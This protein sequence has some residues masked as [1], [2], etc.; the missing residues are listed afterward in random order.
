MSLAARYAEGADGC[1]EDGYGEI[2]D[3]LDDFCFL[4][5]CLI[6]VIVKN[7]LV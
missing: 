1:S 3:F 2:E 7:N 6:L 5:K 4:H